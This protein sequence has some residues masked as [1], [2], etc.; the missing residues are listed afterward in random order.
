MRWIGG[1]RK[2]RGGGRMRSWPLTQPGAI[3]CLWPAPT[4]LHRPRLRPCHA[5]SRPR[6]CR[7][8]APPHRYPA[9]CPIPR[10]RHPAPPPHGRGRGPL[11]LLLLSSSSLLLLLSLALALSLS[12]LLCGVWWWEQWGWWGDDG[13]C[14]TTSVTCQR[15]TDA[16]CWPW[17]V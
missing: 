5:T 12:S 3:P 1:G 4:A 6:R 15:H 11:S 7:H 16:H 14:R 8:P 10:A 17:H 9:R 2:E 13:G